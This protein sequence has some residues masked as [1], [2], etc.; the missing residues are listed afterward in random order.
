VLYLLR[1]Q[2][3][4]CN[5]I[6]STILETIKLLLNKNCGDEMK[7]F[8]LNALVVPAHEAMRLIK[9]ADGRLGG[10]GL[11]LKD[12][13]R[14]R[15]REMHEEED[16]EEE[17]KFEREML[18]IEWIVSLENNTETT[19]H[20]GKSRE[21]LEGPGEITEVDNIIL[22]STE[23]VEEGKESCKKQMKKHQRQALWQ[24]GLYQLLF[25]K[26]EDFLDDFD[27]IS[28]SK[29]WEKTKV[30]N[31]VS[32]SDVVVKTPILSAYFENYNADCFSKLL[33][34]YFLFRYYYGKEEEENKTRDDAEVG[35]TDDDYVFNLPY[36][37][38]LPL[39]YYHRIR[40]LHYYHFHQVLLLYYLLKVPLYNGVIQDV[41]DSYKVEL[42]IH[43]KEREKMRENR[44]I[45]R[46]KREKEI[47]EENKIQREREKKK[48]DEAKKNME[49]IQRKWEENMMEQEEKKIRERKLKKDKEER[50]R[51][52]K[53]IAVR[54][55]LMLAAETNKAHSKIII[56]S[57]TPMRQSQHLLLESQRVASSP[58]PISDFP[59]D[60]RSNI[61]VHTA[62]S[63]SDIKLPPEN[64]SPTPYNSFITQSLNTTSPSPSHGVLSYSPSSSSS[65]AA[66]PLYNFSSSP[67]S[68]SCS[69]FK[70]ANMS[71]VD[72]GVVV[73]SSTSKLSYNVN[74]SG[75]YQSPSQR[76]HS[77]LLNHRSESHMVLPSTS[78]SSSSILS[79][80]IS[81]STSPPSSSSISPPSSSSLLSSSPSSSSFNSISSSS[82]ESSPNDECASS[83]VERNEFNYSDLKMQKIPKY[84]ASYIP[85]NT[86]K[87]TLAFNTSQTPY[88]KETSHS[89]HQSGRSHH[90]QKPKKGTQNK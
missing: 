30:Q 55:Q 24:K 33:K 32:V 6:A 51:K 23:K 27:E 8:V 57:L 56:S 4:R 72:V 81:S 75:L 83:L 79:S 9:L 69:G 73:T 16:G 70:Q 63:I 48:R 76:S 65:F 66:S 3:G 61:D 36:Y 82:L 90:N 29:T 64:A 41:C 12:K 21:F 38:H 88:Q 46:E 1:Q 35:D 58:P 71:F 53:Q 54:K 89:P 39:Q 74:G 14:D 19:T 43:I 13:E 11:E 77:W 10:L 49:E 84:F 28:V 68:P 86:N 85:T 31:E 37:Y 34:K 7:S 80:S 5:L 78:P 26:D 2:Q 20:E 67:M 17:D 60:S 25:E 44:K 62:P 47:R 40:I 22:K 42:N 52:E 45:M 50:L 18:G 15:D 59:I 87:R